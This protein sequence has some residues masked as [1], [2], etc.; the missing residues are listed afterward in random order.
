[1]RSP[2]E[3]HELML[4]NFPASLF[5][6]WAES[7]WQRNCLALNSPNNAVLIKDWTAALAAQASRRSLNESHLTPTRRNLV[8]KTSQDSIIRKLRNRK[9]CRV[10]CELSSSDVKGSF[11][12]MKR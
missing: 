6:R 3:M 7:Q 12:G 10:E 11:D 9:C 4:N 1:M 2:T 8:R 5:N